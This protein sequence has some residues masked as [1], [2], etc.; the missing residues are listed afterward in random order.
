MTDL[1][2]YRLDEIMKEILDSS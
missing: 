2:D 1:D